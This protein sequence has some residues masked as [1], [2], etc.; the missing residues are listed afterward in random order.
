[1]VT[2]PAEDS[3]CVIM[4]TTGSVFGLAR[5][6][7]GRWLAARGKA[8]GVQIF[9]VLRGENLIIGVR[10]STAVFRKVHSPL[11]THFQNEPESIQHELIL[12]I[13]DQFGNCR[14][15]SI[16]HEDH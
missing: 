15:W 10:R 12:F 7:V 2:K 11:T 3:K 13:H 4:S 5:A 14:P 16:R 1:M 9:G 6:Y 8:I